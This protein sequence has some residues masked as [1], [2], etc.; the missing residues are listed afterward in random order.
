MLRDYVHNIAMVVIFASFL[1][2]ILP[3]GK[4]KDYVKLVMG[5]AVILAVISPVANIFGG[6]SLENFFEE[7]RAQF[8]LAELNLSMDIARNAA[9]G[10]FGSENTMLAAVLEE[11]RSGLEA[12]MRLIISNLGHELKESRIYIDES[13]E[14]FGLITELELI[15]TKKSDD[16]S[17]SLIRVDRV[18]VETIGI[19]GTENIDTDENPEINAIKNLLSDFYNLS[20]ENIHIKVNE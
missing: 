15:I 9:A 10:D 18:S 7:A 1:G 11:Y 2:L 16:A 3:R 14:N 4:Y 8:N 12:Q 20:V 13:N 17:N 6:G 19:T 5:L